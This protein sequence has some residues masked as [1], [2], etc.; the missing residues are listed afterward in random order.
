MSRVQNGRADSS[1][2]NRMRKTTDSSLSLPRKRGYGQLGMTKNEGLSGT[3]K[4]VPS[5]VFRDFG[6]FQ[7]TVKPLGMTNPEGDLE[8]CNSQLH[9]WQ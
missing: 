8:L 6:R 9:H 1:R 3:T 2:L 4:V 5:Q 7:Q